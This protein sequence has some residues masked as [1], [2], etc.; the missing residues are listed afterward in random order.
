LTARSVRITGILAAL[1]SRSTVS[2]PVVDHRREGD[3]VD[4][5]G[6]EAADR[7]DL[8]LLLLLRVGELQLDACF[9]GG[10]LDRLAV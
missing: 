10:G 5:L 6:D 9:L 7:L 4:L 3:H 2:Q 8:V 1:A